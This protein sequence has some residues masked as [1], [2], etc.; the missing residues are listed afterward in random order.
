[1][2]GGWIARSALAL[3]VALAC[4]AGAIVLAGLRDDVQVSDVGIVLGSKVMPDGAPSDRLR[5]RLD[6]AAGLYRQGMFKHVI[7]SGGTGV[8]GFSEARV[9]ADYLVERRAVP[10]AAILVDEH[11]DTTEATARNSAAIMRVHGFD[12]AMVI[13]QYFHIARCRYALRHA[14]IQEVHA[15]HAVY[16]EPRDAYSTLRELIALPVYWIRD[17]RRR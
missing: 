10:R 11:G 4:A 2:R 15:A 12:S 6:R 9:M 17:L 1:M 3:L 5:A 7:V 13:T 8:E 16:V 14:G